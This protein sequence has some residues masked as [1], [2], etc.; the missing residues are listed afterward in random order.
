M[1]WLKDKNGAIFRIDAI[2]AVT[3]MELRSDKRDQTKVTEV[4][5]RITT[6]GG[7]THDTALAFD[8]VIKLVDPSLAAPPAIDPGTP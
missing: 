5:A 4:H 1:A 8:D 6:V 3:P 7:H 2:T